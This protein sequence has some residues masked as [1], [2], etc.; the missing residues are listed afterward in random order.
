MKQK[1][2]IA[3]HG[4][5]AEGFKTALDIIVGPVAGLQTMNCYLEEDFDLERS[6]NALF[7]ETDF[8]NEELYVFTDLLGGSVNN[9]FFRHLQ[10]TPFNLITNTTLGL[11]MDFCLTHPDV[12]EL[13]TK[14]AS[15]EFSAVLCNELAETMG[16]FEE[17]DL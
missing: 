9:G 11:L 16:S 13:K 14:L 10:D 6:V 1:I 2:V 3:T 4:R 17:D 7:D 8:E 15:G 5:L 12:N